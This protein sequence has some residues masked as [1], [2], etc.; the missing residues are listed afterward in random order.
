V[1][2]KTVIEDSLIN[3][4]SIWSTHIYGVMVLLVL[5]TIF[6]TSWF[7]GVLGEWLV[8]LIIKL[9]F[10]QPDYYLFKDVLLPTAKG[11]TQIDHVLVSRFG[12]FVIETKNMK[13][14]IFG[15]ENQAKWLQQIYKHKA[16]FQNPVHQNFKHK[17]AL[18]AVLEV[19][20]GSVKS[21]IVF[22]GDAIFKTPMP[23]NV[24]YSSGLR[25]YTKSYSKECFTEAEM[26]GLISQLSTGKLA[27]SFKNKHEHVK[28]V[29][30]FKS[31]SKQ[32]DFT[33]KICIDK[34]N[35]PSFTGIA[36]LCPKCGNDLVLRTAKRGN[37][38]GNEFYGCSAF[39]KCRFIRS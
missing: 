24:I 5:V 12:I 19:D 35:K 39:P 9:S 33:Q 2:D 3:A 8:N 22:V 6:R 20:A 25:K 38:K 4:F 13:G 15:K 23:S 16:Y 1:L 27:S 34:T 31:N 28:Y 36:R 14:W 17:R 7:K 18:E 32:N 30:S 21:I 37:N 11:T 10:K 26:A 29:K